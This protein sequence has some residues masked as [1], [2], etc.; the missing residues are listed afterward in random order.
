MGIMARRV[1]ATLAAWACGTCVMAQPSPPL[2]PHGG[3]FQPTGEGSITCAGTNVTVPEEDSNG[4]VNSSVLFASFPE[5]GL[6]PWPKSI[7]IE[8]AHLPLSAANAIVASSAEA[9]PLASL[10]AAEIAAATD[11]DLKLTAQ[12]ASVGASTA[13]AGNIV[14]T[15]AAVDGAAGASSLT[16]T[17][18]GVALS[19]ASY[20]DLVPATAT[21]LQALERSANH[22]SFPP[23]GANCSSGAPTW[24]LPFITVD[25]VPE[26]GIRGAMVDAARVWLPLSALKGYVVLCRLYKINHLHIHFTDDSAFTFPSTKF[27]ELAAEAKFKYKLEDLHQLQAFAKQRGVMII[28]EMDVP[29]HASGLVT[30]RPDVFAFPSSPHTGIIWFTNASVIAAVQTIFDEISQVFPSPY[31]HCGGDEVNFGAL[32]KLPEITAAIKE[33]GLKSTTDLYRRE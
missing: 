9:W 13:G 12:N 23:T 17:A 25:D 29:G 15:I 1:S 31:V 5:P 27:P 21:L 32:E 3:A 26:F 16:V 24:R 18:S 28:G 30:A 11:G 8:G 2:P 6:V 4:K 22:D 33:L 10:L 19:A 7:A 14:L 20:D